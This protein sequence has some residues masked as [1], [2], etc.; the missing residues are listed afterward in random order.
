[1]HNVMFI[2]AYTWRNNKVIVTP[3]NDVATLFW[4]NCD[5]M[6]TSCF[7]WDRKPNHDVIKLTRIFIYN[8][9]WN[10]WI[11]V[12]A[13]YR[14]WKYRIG[15]VP[16]CTME[17]DTRMLLVDTSCGK[18]LLVNIVFVSSSS[19]QYTSYMNTVQS[20][21]SQYRYKLQSCLLHRYI[22]A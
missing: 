8:P 7:Q 13:V 3:Q 9:T 12:F 5:I 16:W 17:F 2:T 4:Y 6:I 21:S 22:L 1:M 20:V 14:H 19:I 11:A 18:T 15:A 10:Y